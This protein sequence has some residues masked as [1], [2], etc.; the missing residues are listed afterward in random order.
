MQ[1][2]HV[3]GAKFWRLYANDAAC[4]WEEEEDACFAQI[5]GHVFGWFSIQL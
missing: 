4:G 5:Y 3:P 1:V 2:L